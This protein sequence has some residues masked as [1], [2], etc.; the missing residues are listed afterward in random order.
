MIDQKT[1][2]DI[3]AENQ[4]LIK[5]LIQKDEEIRRLDS[6]ISNQNQML[7][8]AT[9]NNPIIRVN[10][11]YLTEEEFKARNAMQNPTLKNLFEDITQENIE[12][13]KE[14]NNHLLEENKK[15]KDLVNYLLNEIS[16]TKDIAKD[17][18]KNILYKLS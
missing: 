10:N 7:M 3:I 15:L 2:E 8:I 18:F 11:Q 1:V 4:R 16:E 12:K 13:I 6:I 5:A 17:R 9:K 14:E